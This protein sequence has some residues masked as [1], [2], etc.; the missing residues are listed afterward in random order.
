MSNDYTP[1]NVS[2]G[3]KSQGA[4]NTNLTKIAEAIGKQLS[5]TSNTDNSMFVDLDMNGKRIIN[6]DGLLN[7]DGIEYT[8]KTYVDEQDQSIE[9]QL[10]NELDLLA[11]SSSLENEKTI[12]QEADSILSDR[13]HNITIGNVPYGTKTSKGA[14]IQADDA[15]IDEGTDDSRVISVRGAK[16]M[17]DN[18]PVVSGLGRGDAIW[19][20]ESIGDLDDTFIKHNTNFA[21]G[22]GE[23]YEELGQSSSDF[24]EKINVSLDGAYNFITD[25]AI[26]T[27]NYGIKSIRTE[28]YIYR[29]ISSST[30]SFIDKSADGI[31]FTVVC[32]ILDTFGETF[33]NLDEL[34]GLAYNGSNRIMLYSNNNYLL[35]DTV[36]DIPATGLIPVTHPYSKYEGI[37]WNPNKNCWF[38]CGFFT[39]P[40]S[41]AKF[42]A[43][44]SDD[45]INW[46]DQDFVQTDL[47]SEGEPEFIK[48]TNSSG[49]NN[50]L[51]SIVYDGIKGHYYFLSLDTLYIFNEETNLWSTTTVPYNNSFSDENNAIAVNSKGVIYKSSTAKPLVRSGSLI[52][53][54]DSGDTWIETGAIFP[55]SYHPTD[56]M[57]I[58]LP[59]DDTIIISSQR[60]RR[61]VSYSNIKTSP[62]RD[63]NNP[64]LLRE[65]SSFCYNPDLSRMFMYSPYSSVSSVGYWFN[66]NFITTYKTPDMTNQ[67]YGKTVPYFK[68]K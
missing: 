34:G 44:T 31:N 8:L 62:T 47:N 68:A 63:I 3:F 17:I 18:Q 56:D 13:I 23:E 5:R 1:A 66:M 53:S 45:G 36:N 43:S 29:I 46:T 19:K 11:L 39:L 49:L 12:R 51:G 14:F 55:N 25:T 65:G 21:G 2:G 7:S 54:E 58:E 24:L 40:S 4:I 38:R 50:S 37:N 15:L 30:Q 59:G 48:L 41:D 35:F 52:Y 32:D 20:N 33:A 10:R 27:S 67:E 9:D 16:R 42:L 6:A 26:I 22:V 57:Q 28:S 64:Y 60:G 61:T